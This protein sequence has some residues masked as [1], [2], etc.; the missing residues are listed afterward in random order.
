MSFPIKFSVDNKSERRVFASGL[1]FLIHQQADL[2]FPR[3]SAFRIDKDLNSRL[4]E[5]HFG[6]FFCSSCMAVAERGSCFPVI[7]SHR[8][9]IK[10]S[11]WTLAALELS[12]SARE[13]RRSS[14]Y[15]RF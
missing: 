10:F 7:E 15:G 3:F 9:S 14:N 1:F 6:I 5:L 12:K 2:N 8:K 13:D 4:S 11:L